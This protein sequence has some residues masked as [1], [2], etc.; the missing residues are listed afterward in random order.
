MKEEIQTPA[1]TVR[2][3]TRIRIISVKTATS[4]TASGVDDQALCLNGRTGTVRRIDDAGNLWDDWGGL[5]V[6]PDADTF[7][8]IPDACLQIV[9]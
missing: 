4:M 2:P 6:L 1:G 3:G 8:I 7:E 5:A 9:N